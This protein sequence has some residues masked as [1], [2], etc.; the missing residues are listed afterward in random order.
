M[1]D[2]IKK[3]SFTVEAACVMPVILLVLMGTLY[4]NFYI[5]NRAW[6]TAAAYEA[7]VTGSMQRDADESV[8]YETAQMKG[9]AL[10]NTGFFGAENI[11]V[12]TSVGKKIMVTYDLDT[13]VGFAGMKWHMRTVGESRVLC[14]AKWVRKA[15]AAAEVL[16]EIG[17]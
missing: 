3:G 6:L 14:P 8:M 5:H 13:F 17:E 7:S 10:A 1:E 9:E 12:Q 2:I 16:N 15:K 11:T 4:L